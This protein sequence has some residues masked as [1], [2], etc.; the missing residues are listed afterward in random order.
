MIKAIAV[1]R[2][3]DVRG[4]FSEIFRASQHNVSFLQD[5][6]SYSR[7]A[8]TLRGLHTQ[9]GPL[10]QTQLLTVLFGRILDVIVSI[11]RRG[12][13]VNY[14]AMDHIGNNQILIPPRT[15]HGFVTLTD[16]V[17]LLYKSNRYFE[18]G[19]DLKVDPFDKKLSINWDIDPEAAII[20][21]SDKL[22]MS[23]DSFISNAVIL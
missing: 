14:N 8:G 21:E 1:D 6:V 15:L 23:Y 3:F 9:I 2:Y 4:H 10:A 7:K 13:T 19:V 17:V 12:S 16:D 18:H 11:D 5:S 20:S 22:A